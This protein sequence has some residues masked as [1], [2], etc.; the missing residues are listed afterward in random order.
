MDPSDDL[1]FL[2]LRVEDIINFFPD[3]ELE[4]AMHIRDIGYVHAKEGVSLG[5]NRR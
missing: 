3:L 5:Q 2:T 1:S 4:K